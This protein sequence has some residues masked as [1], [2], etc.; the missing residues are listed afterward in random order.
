MAS[1]KGM[2]HPQARFRRV[3]QVLET[4]GLADA[5]GRKVKSSSGGMNRR[6]GIAQALV[7]EPRLLIVAE[8]TAGLDS[9][10]RIR[11]RNLLVN[12]ASDRVVILSTHIVE[13]IGQTCLDMAVLAHGQILFRG[14]PSALIE[15]ARGHV[16]I[17]MSNNLEK[18]NH[19]MTV[20]SMM[21][22]TDGLQY[23][24]VG[25]DAVAYPQAE[26]GRWLRLVDER[27]WPGSQ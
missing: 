7:N 17:L 8:P 5:V 19:D 18:P 24:L 27:F 23:R 20:V 4:V 14:S 1:L 25:P 9:E 26:P 13:D 11:F 6:V 12:L 2:D 3:D 16:W 15:A 22:L 21:H 10:E